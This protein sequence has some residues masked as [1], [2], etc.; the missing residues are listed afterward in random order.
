MSERER[1]IDDEVEHGMKRAR[2]VEEEEVEE[3]EIV[4]QVCARCGTVRGHGDGDCP[5][6]SF[7][8]SPERRST[9]HTTMVTPPSSPKAVLS[10]PPRL[11]ATSTVHSDTQGPLS[12]IWCSR[13]GG[14]VSRRSV[15]GR[16]LWETL[17]AKEEGTARDTVA[18]SLLGGEAADHVPTVLRRF[19]QA[20]DEGDPSWAQVGGWLRQALRSVGAQNP[21][22][23]VGPRAVVAA[24]RV[25]RR[26]DMWWLAL[27]PAPV[28]P[29][30]PLPTTPAEATSSFIPTA[31]VRRVLDAGWSVCARPDAMVAAPEGADGVADLLSGNLFSDPSAGVALGHL[32][33]QPLEPPPA[34][35]SS[36][37]TGPAFDFAFPDVSGDGTFL[38]D[39][40]PPLA[41]PDRSAA[42]HRIV[43]PT[44][45]P[46]RPAASAG[47]SPRSSL[48]PSPRRR[49]RPVDESDTQ[50]SAS[51]SVVVNARPAIGRWSLAEHVVLEYTWDAAD[52]ADDSTSGVEVSIGSFGDPRQTEGLQQVSQS[53]ARRGAATASTSSSTSTSSSSSDRA[54]RASRRSAAAAVPEA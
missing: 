38:H 17:A 27:V 3:E 7:A 11:P 16:L 30:P 19:A 36:T 5:L 23:G 4:S 54:P 44:S 6:L 14:S 39:S 32:A 24:A 31:T 33:P 12:F 8:S 29:T 37:D 41:S 21:E 18:A 34:D 25:G 51:P 40:F 15:D 10:S 35:S 47:R 26:R 28:D 43:T 52:R 1:V 53:L 50:P 2:R 9:G 20:V 49:R 45:T 46:P 48:S 42:R 22:V 13:E